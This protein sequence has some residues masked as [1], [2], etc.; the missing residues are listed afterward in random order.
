[1][2]LGTVGT[3]VCSI[4]EVDQATEAVTGVRIINCPA[5]FFFHSFFLLF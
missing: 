1:M 2:N 4:L 3:S 5:Y